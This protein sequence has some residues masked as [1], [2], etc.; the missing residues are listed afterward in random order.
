MVLD[1]ES[2]SVGVES[3]IIDMTTS[4]IVMLRAGGC[5]IEDIEQFSKE[6][7]LLSH[8]NPDLPTSPGQML[9]HYAPNH[10]FRINVE[11]PEAD[12]F[13]I[14][15][16]NSEKAM[17]NLSPSG[18]LRE[19]ASN[20]FAYLRQADEQNV[21]SKIAMAPIPNKDLG[22]AINDRIKRASYK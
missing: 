18:D 16:G 6:K 21:Y 2:C 11:K 12:E 9:K 5:A 8:G 22:L 14:G 10:S 3:T 17:L 13:Y 4:K 19:A 15:F 1:G 7:V 20:L